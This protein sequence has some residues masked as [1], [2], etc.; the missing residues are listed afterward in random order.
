MEIF[1]V[2][3]YEGDEI[4]FL[5][6]PTKGDVCVTTYNVADGNETHVLISR[7]DAYALRDWLNAYLYGPEE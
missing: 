6:R 4:E 2:K 5:V 7:D 1:K 3:D